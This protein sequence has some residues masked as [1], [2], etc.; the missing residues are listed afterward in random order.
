[1]YGNSF[2]PRQ[3]QAESKED[4]TLILSLYTTGRVFYVGRVLRP[5][6]INFRS[7]T[8]A[9][10]KMAIRDDESAAKTLP[11]IEVLLNT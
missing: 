1:M 10:I 7:P 4:D 6:S 2:T 11:K 5:P 8:R 9:E 3:I